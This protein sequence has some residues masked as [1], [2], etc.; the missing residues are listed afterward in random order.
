MLMESSGSHSDNLAILRA[1]GRANDVQ[2]PSE[3]T[4]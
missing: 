4:L 2:T 3:E 1:Q